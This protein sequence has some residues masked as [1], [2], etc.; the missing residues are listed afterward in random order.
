M[1]RKEN[2]S[3]NNFISVFSNFSAFF[4]SQKKWRKKEKKNEEKSIFMY[5]KIF[6]LL[7]SVPFLLCLFICPCESQKKKKR[8]GRKKTMHNNVWTHLVNWTFLLLTVSSFFYFILFFTS[9]FFF[10]SLSLFNKF[11]QRKSKR[12]YVCNIFIQIHYICS[13][14]KKK[15]K[16]PISPQITD[17]KCWWPKWWLIDCCKNHKWKC[18]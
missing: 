9:F 6:S 16:K 14:S 8:E 3:G 17:H 12:T 11:N 13:S 5:T 1:V 15:K 4:V 7:L 10:L 2:S 18:L